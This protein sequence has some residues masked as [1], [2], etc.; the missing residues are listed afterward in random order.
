M[1]GTNVDNE[2]PVTS[3]VYTHLRAVW[4]MQHDLV[5]FLLE[6]GADV[7]YQ[8]PRKGAKS[9]ALRA[10]ITRGDKAM[11]TF[12]AQRG[13][14]I[15]AV[16]IISSSE[17]SFMAGRRYLTGIDKPQHKATR[18]LIIYSSILAPT[19]LTFKVVMGLLYRLLS[20]RATSRLPSS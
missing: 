16:Q 15:N 13:V 11:I 20:I 6:K 7:N 14:D 4:F 3:Y 18:L 1:G 2:R 5:A 8:I 10:A 9:S 19:L 17:L 12:L